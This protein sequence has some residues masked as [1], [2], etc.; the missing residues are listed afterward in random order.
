MFEGAIR[1][2]GVKQALACLLTRAEKTSVRTE[3]G[4]RERLVQGVMER[5]CTW[6]ADLAMEAKATKA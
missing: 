2:F 6:E 1:V 5:H 4:G 3:L